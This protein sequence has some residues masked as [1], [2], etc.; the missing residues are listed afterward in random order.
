MSEHRESEC[1]CEQ[2]L[3]CERLLEDVAKAWEAWHE[4]RDQMVSEEVIEACDVA[5]AHVKARAAL[6]DREVTMKVADFC[7]KLRE[8]IQAFEAFWDRGH[9]EDAEHFPAELDGPEWE[10]Q[11]AM[12]CQGDA[13]DMGVE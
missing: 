8:T 2:A 4:T 11:F 9:E 12:F 3:E 5:V 1:N 13:E 7:G 10:E 6:R